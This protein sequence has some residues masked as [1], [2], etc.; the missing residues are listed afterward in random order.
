MLHEITKVIESF[1]HPINRAEVN[2]SVAKQFNL[3]HQSDKA[4]LYIE[5][6]L[7]EIALIPIEVL[8]LRYAGIGLVNLSTISLSVYLLPVNL[9]VNRVILTKG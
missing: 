1:Q 5:Q 8:A 2:I 7:Q 4:L 9:Q 3:A 6:T